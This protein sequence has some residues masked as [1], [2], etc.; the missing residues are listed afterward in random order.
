LEQNKTF[1]KKRTGTPPGRKEPSEGTR[2]SR[3]EHP[4]QRKA[5][6]KGESRRWGEKTAQQKGEG[7]AG[8]GAQ[9]KNPG[10]KT[11]PAGRDKRIT[12]CRVGN[13]KRNP[14]EI[15]MAK[16]KKPQHPSPIKKRGKT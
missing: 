11:D 13:Y 5:C 3:T 16:T 12:L 14:S 6:G 7:N 10:E 8:H 9:K 1:Q 4:F 2:P 15:T